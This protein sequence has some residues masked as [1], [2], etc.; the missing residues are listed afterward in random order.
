[1][2]MKIKKPPT[3]VENDDYINMAIQQSLL[4]SNQDDDRH[5][6]TAISLSIQEASTSTAKNLPT[7]SLDDLTEEQLLEK[8]ISMSLEKN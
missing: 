1:M 7:S 3:T 4:Q 2:K 5:L 8:A 6:Q